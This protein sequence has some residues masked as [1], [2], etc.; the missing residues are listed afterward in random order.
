[1]LGSDWKNGADFRPPPDMGFD[2]D[3]GNL[4][5]GFHGGGASPFSD[6]FDILFGQGVAGGATTA[7]RQYYGAG[8]RGR[9]AVHGQDQEAELTVS[10]E[11]VAHGTT[12]SIEVNTPGRKKKVLEV[13]IPPGV[14][15][16]SRIR[17]PG[18]GGIGFGAGKRGDLYLKIRLA[19]H[20]HYAV[21]GDNLVSEV[22]ITPGLAVHGGEVPV[23]TIDGKVTLTIP[24]HTQSGKVLRLRNRGLPRLKQSGRGDQLV[25]VRIVIPEALSEAEQHLYEQLA[26]L[27]KQGK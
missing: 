8:T 23:Q 7:S 2:F 4:S 10:I 24:P 22:K 25:R 20:H 11:D 5:G 14:R 15:T 26:K 18:E 1:M 13:K 12:R 21:E 27:E 16:G 3:F 19:P 17:V 6:F 9:A